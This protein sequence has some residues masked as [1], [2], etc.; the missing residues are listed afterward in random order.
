[1]GSAS[2]DAREQ[3]A[4]TLDLYHVDPKLVRKTPVDMRS[5]IF[6]RDELLGWFKGFGV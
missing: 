5:V 3:L 4:G 6:N 1:M 2:D